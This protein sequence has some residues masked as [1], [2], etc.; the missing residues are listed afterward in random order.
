MLRPEIASRIRETCDLGLKHWYKRN[1]QEVDTNYNWYADH[2]AL[3]AMVLEEAEYIAEVLSKGTER[4]P[5]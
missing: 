3:K 5:L 4:S 1:M 2:P